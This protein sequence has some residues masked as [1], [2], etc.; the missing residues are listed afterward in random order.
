MWFKWLFKSKQQNVPTKGRF[1]I[2]V[3]QNQIASSFQTICKLDVLTCYPICYKEYIS[4]GFE[5]FL[6][7]FIDP[8]LL[9]EKCQ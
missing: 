8:I 2:K 3:D 6:F 9:V 1:L 7:T 5:F 4:Y